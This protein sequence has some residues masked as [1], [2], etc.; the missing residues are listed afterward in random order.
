MS[1]IL[2]LGDMDDSL[3][4]AERIVAQGVR[5]LKVK[6]GQKWGADLQRLRLL[7][8]QFGIRLI[9]TLTPMSVFSRRTCG[10]AWKRW[11]N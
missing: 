1:Y 9:C 2:G 6:V 5:V 10:G 7:R 3:A 4:E 11:P 8:E